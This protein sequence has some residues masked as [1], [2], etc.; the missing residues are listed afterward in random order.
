[1]ANK[2]KVALGRVGLFNELQ[3]QPLPP[4]LLVSYHQRN[5]NIAVICIHRQLAMSINAIVVR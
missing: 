2:F 5:E 1:M 4:S 3:A